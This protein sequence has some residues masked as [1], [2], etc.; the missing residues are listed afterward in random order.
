MEEDGLQDSQIHLDCT[1]PC[2]RITLST[3][4]SFQSC[5]KSFK[6]C[7]ATAFPRIDGI[8][9]GVSARYY[10]IKGVWL[11]NCSQHLY[12]PSTSSHLQESGR[13]HHNADGNS[14]RICTKNGNLRKD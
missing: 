6:H 2:I 13:L 4:R 1:S 8:H 7:G 5:R 12:S 10:P 14:N 3:G 11:C 9:H